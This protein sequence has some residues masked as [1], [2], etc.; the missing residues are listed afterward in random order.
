VPSSG[1]LLYIEAYKDAILE[2]ADKLYDRLLKY[3]TNSIM[4]NA[5]LSSNAKLSLPQLSS[6]FPGYRN[7]VIRTE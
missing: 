6:M 4:D 1:Q 2:V 7:K 3:F 5:T